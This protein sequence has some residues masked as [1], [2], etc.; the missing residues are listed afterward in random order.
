M[1]GEKAHLEGTWRAVG[2]HL[3]GR[4]KTVQSLIQ[5]QLTGIISL[6]WRVFGKSIYTAVTSNE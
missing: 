4:G 5:S 2:G 3:E 1:E 6:T